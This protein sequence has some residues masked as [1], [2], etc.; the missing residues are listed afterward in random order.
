[1][2]SSEKSVHISESATV[3]C[4]FCL[5]S[6]RRKNYKAHLKKVHPRENAEDLSGRSQQRI[7]SMFSASLS[8]KNQQDSINAAGPVH[9]Q[10]QLV[11]GD[12]DVQSQYVGV[13]PSH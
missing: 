6:L 5:V 7:S 3:K 10:G 8:K 9:V 11:E 2:E 13:D 12:V 1:M 4:R